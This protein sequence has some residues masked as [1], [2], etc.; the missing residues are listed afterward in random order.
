MSGHQ[1]ASSLLLLLVTGAEAEGGELWDF[2]RSLNEE[3]KHFAATQ[4]LHRVLQG[5]QGL[6]KG[7]VVE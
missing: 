7:V 4:V 6:E 5:G 3:E 2:L 1:Q